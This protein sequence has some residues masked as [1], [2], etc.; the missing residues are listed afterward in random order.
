[1]LPHPTPAALSAPLAVRF[2]LRED[3]EV[4]SF[5]FWISGGRVVP[6][7]RW[8]VIRGRGTLKPLR[9]ATYLLVQAYQHL[10]HPF[11]LVEHH[12]L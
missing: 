2:P 9:L 10:M 11:W 3:N 6:L 7:G 4:S 12:G 1:L 8:R 5:T